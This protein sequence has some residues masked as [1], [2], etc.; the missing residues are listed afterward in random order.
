[1]CAIMLPLTGLG[2]PIAV[3]LGS[4][5]AIGA[6]QLLYRFITVRME[7]RRL[8]AQG[9][10]I[11]SHSLLLGHLPILAQMMKSKPRDLHWGYIPQMIVEDWKTF[12]PDC[13]ACPG[14][15]YL[16]VWPVGPP[17]VYTIDPAMATQGVTNHQQLQKVENMLRILH[18]LAQNLDILTTH[19]PQWR[20]W[21]S[22][23]NP[24]FSSKSITALVPALL[25]EAVVF[26]NI[27]RSKV[28]K[29]GSWGDVFPLEPLTTNL[30]FDVIGR[31]A[32]DVRLDEQ[33]RGPGPLQKALVDQLAQGVFEANIW[34][35]PKRLNPIRWWKIARNN[36]TMRSVLLPSIFSRLE[37]SM[38]TEPSLKPKTIVDLAVREFL[39]EAPTKGTQ[40]KVDDAFIDTVL[41][42]LKIFIFAGHDVTSTTIC[43]AFHCLAKFPE[44]AAKMR[45]E[46]DAV[47]GTDLEQVVARIHASPHI[48]NQLPYTLAFIKETLRLFP[49]VGPVR[50]GVPNF[51][52]DVP[53]GV[54]HPTKGF[55][56]LDAVRATSRAEHIWMRPDDFLPQRFLVA[57]DDPLYPP[58]NAWHPFGLGPRGCIG[59]ELALTEVKVVLALVVR[60]L[61]I[62]CAWEK[63]D[64]LKGTSKEVALKETIEGDRC[65]Q[66]GP[67]TPHTK[68]QMPVHVRLRK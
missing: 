12:F 22:R 27:L 30:T 5:I 48:L 8:K 32:L 46:H 68:E 33:L 21:R 59:Q 54:P 62:D 7:F 66:S 49:G 17:T 58:K 19:G 42:Q 28:G 51:N 44:K 43:W 29:D 15:I 52:F 56:I 16:D 10:P 2:S 34:T 41:A 4:I 57:P 64:A 3:G 47:L 55:M 9:I 67:N 14:I 40:L 53:G 11:M 25:E 1:M 61:E 50:G 18:P 63:W 35:I 26:R 13:T 37:S 65:Y 60:E 23:F 24:A 31:A 45:A 39:R 20:V 38:A 36:K 6:A